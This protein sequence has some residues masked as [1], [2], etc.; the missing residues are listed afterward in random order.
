MWTEAPDVITRLMLDLLAPAGPRAKLTVL[1]FHRVLAEPDPLLPQ[2]PDVEGFRAQ[3]RWVAA[4]FNVLALQEAVERLVQRSL[5]A[6]ALA[7]TFDDGYGDNRRLAFPVLR[8]LGLPA[9]FFIASGF[10]G[11]GMMWNDM[12][13]ETIRSLAGSR[14]DLRAAGLGDFPIDSPENKRRTIAA[15]LAALKYLPAQ[16]R[17]DAVDRI[18]ERSPIPLRKDLMMSET[19]VRE[20]VA[21]GMSIGAHTVTHPI[22]ARLPEREA[23]RE[24]AEGKSILEGIV[25][26]PVTLFAYPNGKPGRDYGAQHVAMIKSLGFHA[27]VSTAWGAARAG[28]DICQIPRFTPWDTAQWKYGLRLLRNLT[29]PAAE[30]VISDGDLESGEKAPHALGG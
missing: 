14:I 17:S 20:L 10:I 1:I 8:E 21:G 3:M 19:E 13:I 30:T 2:E 16:Q 23:R 29:G 4:W 12:V 9:T 26:E 24:I 5:P 18:A 6:R 28:C 22:L 11:T 15:V 25:G 7:I 27:A